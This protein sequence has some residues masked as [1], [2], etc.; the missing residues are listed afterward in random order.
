M[1][2]QTR[3]DEKNE[4]VTGSLPRDLRYRQQLFP[5]SDDLVFKVSEKGFVPIPIILRKLFRFLSTPETR[6]LLYLYLRA[7]RY[8]ICFP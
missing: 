6:I 1:T 8:A 3:E 2:A 4:M 7:S 5:G